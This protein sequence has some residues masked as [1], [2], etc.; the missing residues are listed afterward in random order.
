[1]ALNH[2]AGR[3]LP[4]WKI[5]MKLS[6]RQSCERHGEWKSSPKSYID[7]GREKRKERGRYLYGHI[8]IVSIGYWMKERAASAPRTPFTGHAT[9]RSL[10]TSKIVGVKHTK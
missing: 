1:M 7:K 2:T 6:H 9:E 10:F 4:W 5:E 3:D 8:F